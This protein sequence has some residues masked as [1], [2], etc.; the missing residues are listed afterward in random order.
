MDVETKNA[1]SNIAINHQIILHKPNNV[2]FVRELTYGVLENKMLLDYIIDN[3]IPR[4]V[5]KLKASDLTI[6]RM[7]I[8][9][10][11]RMDSVPEYAAVN[12]SV[13]LA[14]KFARGRE[15][16]I[17]GVLRSYINEKYNIKLP[18]R[19]EDEVSHLAIKYSYEP[20]II[21][22]WLESYDI[23]FVES[24]LKAGNETPSVCIRLNWL[25][26]MKPDLIKELE[27][28]GF[29][30]EEGKLA[31]NALHVKGQGLLESAFY[32]DGLFSVQDEACQMVAQML[33]PKQGDVVMDMCAAPGGKALSIAE[34]MNNKGTVIASDIYKRR[35]EIAD[36]EAKRLGI[37]IIQTKTWDATRVDSTM[38]EKADKVLCD[39]PCSGF[40]VIRRKP[41]IKYRK[42]EKEVEMLP[43][44][45]LAILKASASYVKPGGVLMYCTCTINPYENERVVADFL[46]KTN[47]F[48]VE[49]SKQFM[50]NVDGTDG[51]FICKMRKTDN[52][53]NQEM[54]GL[55]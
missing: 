22:L 47:S 42:N 46:R 1:Y 41:E 15:G 11:A 3:L 35:V 10:L 37:N 4:D 54:A 29:E 27:E 8:Y 40:G 34:R 13:V 48:K 39:V 30:V 51:F 50:P 43:A 52:I 21:R 26:I 5:S 33:D 32:R 18:D 20:W 49:E 7:G 2:S 16:F 23:D 25:K 31:S 19:G 6:L 38:V 14:K 36:R 12:E 55:R 17:N 28:R 24:L 9:Q 53:I 44:K 45:Q